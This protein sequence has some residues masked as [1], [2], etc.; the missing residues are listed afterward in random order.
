M[1]FRILPEAGDGPPIGTVRVVEGGFEYLLEE[2]ALHR[3]AIEEVLEEV[4][5]RGTRPAYGDSEDPDSACGGYGRVP[6]T[7]EDKM[8]LAVKALSPLP[9]RVEQVVE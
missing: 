6:A 9:V 3:E 5:A 7:D 2:E 4:A 8:K 1:A